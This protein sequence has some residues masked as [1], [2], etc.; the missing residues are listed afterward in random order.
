MQKTFSGITC[1]FSII[2]Q[3]ILVCPSP[4]KGRQAGKYPPSPLEVVK[5]LLTDAHPDL[6]HRTLYH[7][8]SFD[9]NCRYCENAESI[10]AIIHFETLVQDLEFVAG[11]LNVSVGRQLIKKEQAGNLLS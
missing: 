5:H 3:F 11:L 2:N 10:D 9:H 8:N 1:I 4:K 6:H 7:F